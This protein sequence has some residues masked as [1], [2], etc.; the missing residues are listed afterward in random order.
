MLPLIEIIP[1]SRFRAG[2]RASVPVLSVALARFILKDAALLRAAVRS[3]GEAPWLRQ[4]DETRFG[5]K[6]GGAVP[7]ATAQAG[8]MTVHLHDVVQA[9]T[10]A[11]T[12][13]VL[14]R[15]TDAL[16]L[17]PH[18]FPDRVSQPPGGRAGLVLVLL[19]FQ[20]SARLI[21]GPGE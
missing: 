18:L 13:T 14:G 4:T 8:T 16:G 3:H 2:S 21:T 11:A 9:R 17:V 7:A 10:G 15:V 1:R 5:G 6:A 19:T 12:S 20:R